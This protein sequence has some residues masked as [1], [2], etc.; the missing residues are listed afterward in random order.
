VPFYDIFKENCIVKRNKFFGNK[1]I[2]WLWEFIFIKYR[3]QLLFNHLRRIRSYPYEGE[4]RFRAMFIDI[5]HFEMKLKIKLL[6]P[7]CADSTNIKIFTRLEAE[8]ELHLNIGKYNK[9]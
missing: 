9:L 4:A 1:L 3:P 6:S 5:K 7:K 8:H 2:Q